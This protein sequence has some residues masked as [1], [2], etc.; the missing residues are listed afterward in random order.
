M[1]YA[2][3]PTLD[4]LRYVVLD[5]VHYLQDRYRGAVWE[6][7]IIHLP[8]DDRPRVPLGDGLERGGG[9]RLD[10]D[11][12][13]RRPTA[14]I[15]ETPAGRARAPLHGRRP[16]QPTRC[17]CCPTFVDEP[18]GELRPEPRG[19]AARQSGSRGA[20]PPGRRRGRLLHAVARRRSSTGSPTSAM[21]PAIVLRVQPGRLRR[22]PSSSASPAG[23]RLTTS[24]ASAARSARIAE[25]HTRRPRRRR[26]RR[27]RLRRVARPG[28]RRASPRT[29]PGMVPPMKEAVEEAFTAGSA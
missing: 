9:R 23:L 18:D 12:P 17:T 24:R 27:P 21:L 28:S 2:R 19:L 26:P 10:P 29:T 13:R 6:E 20:R 16:R 3:S 5:E 4:G 11:R 22:T 14:I 15:E 25:A 8:A 7:V 1:I